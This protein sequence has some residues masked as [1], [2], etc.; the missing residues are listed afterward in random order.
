LESYARNLDLEVWTSSRVQNATWNDNTK[1]WRVE[2][3]RT[4]KQDPPRFFDIKHIV[5]ATGFAGN[6]PKVPEIPKKV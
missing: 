3:I 2:I 4:D 5:F 6:V 1:T